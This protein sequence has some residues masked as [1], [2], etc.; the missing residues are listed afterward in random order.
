MSKIMKLLKLFLL[1]F[2]A[3]I[4]SYS[5]ILAGYEFHMSHDHQPL[6]CYSIST[7]VVGDMDTITEISTCKK[8]NEI[9]QP[10]RL[11]NIPLLFILAF[12]SGY[13]F[14]YAISTPKKV[15]LV[16]LSVEDE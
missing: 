3:N 13:Y 8:P 11:K 1:Y 12:I 10:D 14:V 15:S 7:A 4:F 6:S 9:G 16:K 2:A 5:S